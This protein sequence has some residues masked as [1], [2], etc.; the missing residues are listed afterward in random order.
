MSE[1]IGHV[2]ARDRPIVSLSVPGQEDQFLVIVDTGF[3]GQLLIHD[4]AATRLN[5]E[6]RRVDVRVE[7][8]DRGSRIL[9]LGRGSIV[10]FGRHQEVDVWIT[11]AEPGRTTTADQPIGLLG[12]G[13]LS[14]HKLTV[15]FATR[16]VVIS[17]NME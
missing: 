1:I 14:P 15:D 7:F 5:C 6:S 9:D 10:W 16:R 12:T 17:E 8:A 4:A 11:T 3:N 2:D 13:L